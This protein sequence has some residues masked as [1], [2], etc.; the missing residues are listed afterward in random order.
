[1]IVIR[2]VL[3]KQG[4]GHSQGASEGPA[5]KLVHFHL[6]FFCNLYL[7]ILSR[8]VMPLCTWRMQSSRI[9]PLC[10]D[11]WW[12]AALCTLHKKKKSIIK[13][14]ICPPA[15]HVDVQCA[16]Q[17]ASLKSLWVTDFSSHV[18][19]LIRQTDDIWTVWI[20]TRRTCLQWLSLT[21]D[22][23]RSSQLYHPFIYNKRT[24]AHSFVMRNYARSHFCT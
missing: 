17:W 21:L 11:E 5:G 10:S 16:H 7:A 2:G 12:W 20:H 23:L 9:Q 6:L 24:N 14:I 18:S 8:S 3:L 13:P 19:P 1:M 4:S 22:I 15:P